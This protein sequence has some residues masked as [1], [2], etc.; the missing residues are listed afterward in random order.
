MKKE[1]YFITGNREKYQEARL[2][3]PHLK[4][5]VIDLPEI[6][7]LDPQIIIKEKLIRAKEHLES[8]IVVED[9]SLFF[10]CLGKL[11]GPL[12]KW[13]LNEM[14]P[15]RL[16]DLCARYGEFRAE[17]VLTLGY[18]STLNNIYFFN[19]SIEGQIVQPRGKQGFGW[20]SIF[21]PKNH[22][23]TFAEMNKKEKNVISMRGFVFKKLKSFISVENE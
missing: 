16:F 8:S 20:D 12:I 5:I 7:E 14:G 23:K 11:P 21:K 19:N 4:N 2:I 6:Q 3:I 18:I 9:V 17:A 1:I 15:I 10:K 22:D 13:F